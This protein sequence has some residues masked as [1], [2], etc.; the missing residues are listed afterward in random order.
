MIQVAPT[1]EA[2]PG[3]GGMM[4]G[5]NLLEEEEEAIVA[6]GIYTP[7]STT[8]NT[9]EMLVFTFKITSHLL[10]QIEMAVCHGT[11]VFFM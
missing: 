5:F 9:E 10:Y 4:L 3:K 11:I 8:P 7:P 1:V 6:G 2:I